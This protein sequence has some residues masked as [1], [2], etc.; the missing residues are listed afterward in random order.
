MAH[1]ALELSLRALVIPPKALEMSLAIRG[2]REVVW[3]S[4]EIVWG[5]R[6]V[7]WGSKDALLSSSNDT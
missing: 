4:R 2:S 1:P 5:S 6:E 7:P 3:G